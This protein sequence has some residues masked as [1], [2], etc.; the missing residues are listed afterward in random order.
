MTGVEAEGNEYQAV[1]LAGVPQRSYELFYDSETAPPPDFDTAAI[2]ASLAAGYQPTL[3]GLGKQV[4]VL[5]GGQPTA[6]SLSRIV[7]NPLVLGG[8]TVLLVAALAWGL[9]RAGHRLD[10]LSQDDR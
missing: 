10:S 1:F 9:Y 8:I 4:N 7:N 6:F 5:G 3:V 2:S